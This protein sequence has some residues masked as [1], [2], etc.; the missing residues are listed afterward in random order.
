MYHK[1][2]H[3]IYT[4]IYFK[5]DNNVLPNITRILTTYLLKKE[6]QNKIEIYLRNDIHIGLI[7]ERLSKVFKTKN[8]IDILQEIIQFVEVGKCKNI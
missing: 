8:K 1:N 6:N 3:F 4:A 7:L 5:Y 2:N